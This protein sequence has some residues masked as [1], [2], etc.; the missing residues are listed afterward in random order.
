MYAKERIRTNFWTRRASPRQ[1]KIKVTNQSK[2]II[3]ELT[4]FVPFDVQNPQ[5]S[6]LLASRLQYWK[7]GNEM[8]PETQ[9]WSARF[10]RS[11]MKMVVQKL[12]V[13][14]YNN[15]ILEARMDSD[16]VR[17]AKDQA[18]KFMK[19]NDLTG[20][21]IYPDMDN[22][23]YEN[24]TRQFVLRR[25]SASLAD[26]HHPRQK[27]I[28]KKLMQLKDSQQ[29]EVDLPPSAGIQEET[30]ESVDIE[31]QGERRHVTREQDQVI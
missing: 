16:Q 2:L 11:G 30:H 24:I 15:I 8:R 7:E 6:R 3:A 18:P 19:H 28:L 31:I 12:K 5:C 4:F 13:D 9:S 26:S 17:V 22:T 29:M 27:D 20:I 1:V 23:G 21:I 14:D 25:L 10:Y